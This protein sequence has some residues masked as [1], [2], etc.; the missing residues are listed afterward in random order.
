MHICVEARVQTQT[1]LPRC[2]S[3]FPEPGSLMELELAKEA[4]G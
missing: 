3:A 4:T 2:C 1:L